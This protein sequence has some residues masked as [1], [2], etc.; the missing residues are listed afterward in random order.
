VLPGD[1][2]NF[3]GTMQRIVIEKLADEGKEWAKQSEQAD[4]GAF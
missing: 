4:D 1:Y 2:S 3:G